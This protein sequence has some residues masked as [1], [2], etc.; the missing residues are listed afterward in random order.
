MANR[1]S[2]SAPIENKSF[3]FRRENYG[4]RVTEHHR[5]GKV[6]VLF[7]D[8]E[9]LWW[10]IGMVSIWRGEKLE[11]WV[12]T[13]QGGG[14]TYTIQLCSN[15]YEQFFTLDFNPLNGRGGTL[16]FPE[17]AKSGDWC[18]IID[19]AQK[20]GPCVRVKRNPAC[21]PRCLDCGS[22]LDSDGWRW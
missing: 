11:H 6:S 5:L 13:M 1:L 21:R 16:R 19:A 9:M 20:M 2:L 18:S 22:A 15:S 4:C 10:V 7:R 14:C 12:N 17:G 3:D 8:E